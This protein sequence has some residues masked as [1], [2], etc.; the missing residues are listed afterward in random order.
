MALTIPER[1]YRGFE[2]FARLDRDSAQQL[3]AALSTVSPQLR[4]D[5]VAS[6]VSAA[7]SGVPAAETK[8]IVRMLISLYL[9]RERNSQAADELAEEITRAVNRTEDISKPEKWSPEEFQ[10]ALVNFLRIDGALE[11]ISKASSVATD[12]ERVFCSARVV[13]D[14]RPIFGSD[15][16]P[17]PSPFTS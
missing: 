8:R 17:I 13:T 14:V 7:V 1:Y 5:Q 2:S 15:P 11:V 6:Q 4:A 9:L 3:H 10:S 12:Y 16:C